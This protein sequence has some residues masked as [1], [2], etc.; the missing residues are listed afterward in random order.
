MY[1]GYNVIEQWF[2]DVAA[3]LMGYSNNTNPNLNSLLL[4]L[5]LILTTILTP[6][7]DFLTVQRQRHC[8]MGT[9]VLLHINTFS[10][11]YLKY[12]LGL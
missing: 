3:L 11:C 5:T 12:Q 7:L 1:S 9:C 10:V 4:I 2:H 8:S 6:T